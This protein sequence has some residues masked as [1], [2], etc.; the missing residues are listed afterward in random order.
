[1]F[2][3]KYLEHQRIAS[4]ESRELSCR[5]LAAHE[6]R[7]EAGEG[8]PGG[9]R[10][11]GRGRGCGL[12]GG[13][14]ERVDERDEEEVRVVVRFARVGLEHDEHVLHESDH[15]AHELELALI[16][17]TFAS[18]SASAPFEL[19]AEHLLELADRVSARI[20]A[21]RLVLA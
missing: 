19:R 18:A 10:G 2:T 8:G 15:D 1:M 4:E 5:A 16:E 11:P 13:E 9:G 3:L 20:C 6:R 12:V 14:R 7:E 17:R 21:Q